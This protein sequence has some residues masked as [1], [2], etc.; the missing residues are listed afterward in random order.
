MVFL[1]SDWEFGV[2]DKQKSEFGDVTDLQ[3]V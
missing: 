1:L 3:V 2:V